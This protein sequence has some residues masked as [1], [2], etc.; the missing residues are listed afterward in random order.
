[1]NTA[2]ASSIP[3]INGLTQSRGLHTVVVV[4]A[5]LLLSCFMEKVWL[6]IDG[7]GFQLTWR[8]MV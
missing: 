1:M 3:F 2:A 6:G 8:F 5:T 4:V 7:R